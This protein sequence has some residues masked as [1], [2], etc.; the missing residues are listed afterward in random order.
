MTPNETPQFLPDLMNSLTRVWNGLISPHPSVQEIGEKRRAQLLATITLVL[1]PIYAW[2]MISR[3]ESYSSFI[4]LLSL[5]IL[6][7]ATSRTAYHRIVTYFFC[8]G[9]AEYTFISLRL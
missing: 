4:V 1:I 3:P 7:Y 6:V 9:F 8:F 5:A 2:A